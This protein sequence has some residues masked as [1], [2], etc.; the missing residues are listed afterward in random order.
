[1]TSMMSEVL[2]TAF[3][4]FT[5]KL[6]GG[7]T[8]MSQIYFI[9]IGTIMLII[10]PTATFMI[11]EGKKTIMYTVGS[12]VKCKKCLIK[13]AEIGILIFKK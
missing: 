6:S 4:K 11:V 2:H 8:E 10:I 1:M 5:K 12:T 13:R 7:S 9:V 3:A